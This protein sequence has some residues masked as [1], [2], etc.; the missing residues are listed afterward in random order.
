MNR[1]VCTVL[2]VIALLALAATSAFAEGSEATMSSSVTTEDGYT[3]EISKAYFTN[4]SVFIWYKLSGD[5][6]YTEL[7][8]G[9]PD[10]DIQ[11]KYVFEDMIPAEQW[12]N[13]NPSLQAELDWLDGKGQ[14]WTFDKIVRIKDGIELEDG[15]YADI[16][17]G[18]EAYLEDGTIS[19]WKECKMPSVEVSDTM[20]FK[21]VLS[22]S[23]STRFQDGTTHKELNEQMNQTYILVKME[24]NDPH[25]HALEVS[26][27]EK[28][29]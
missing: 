5:I 7:H 10:K 21:L 25:Q 14:R 12:S 19:G 6:T 29:M 1:K 22:R 2:I 16:I 15:Q 23:Q 28:D 17:A 3:V 11:W 13:D 4:D 9:A 20:T 27:E 24:K 26:C 8:E 18:E